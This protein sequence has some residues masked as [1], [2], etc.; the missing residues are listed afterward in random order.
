MTDEQLLLLRA[1]ICRAGMDIKKAMKLQSQ[2][3]VRA[4]L[5]TH[6]RCNTFP[7]EL[8][9]HTIMESVYGPDDGE[10]GSDAT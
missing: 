7:H 3:I 9:E 1:D 4:V 5:H 6:P 8:V 2:A 10:G